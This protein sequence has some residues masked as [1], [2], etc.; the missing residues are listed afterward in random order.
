M[1]IYFATDHAG[2]TLKNKLVDFVR[3]LGHDVDDLGAHELDE[4][5]DYPGIIARAAREVSKNP[6]TTKA[7]VLGGSGQGEAMVANRFEGVRA[8]VWYGEEDDILTL[9]REH[10]D[11]NILSLGARFVDEEEAKQAVEKWLNTDFSG[12]E[13][14]VRRIERIEAVHKNS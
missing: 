5:D 2:F 8:T 9:S 11:A 4:T 6:G 13:R 14:H 1:K 12:E 3:E 7:I 10:N